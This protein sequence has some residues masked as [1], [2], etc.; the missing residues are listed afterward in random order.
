M[1]KKEQCL[2]IGV[3]NPPEWKQNVENKNENNREEKT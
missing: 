1:D 3:T 2:H